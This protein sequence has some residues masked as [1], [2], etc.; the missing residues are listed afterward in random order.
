[1]FPHKPVLLNTV[2]LQKPVTADDLKIRTD[3]TGKVSV[4]VMDTLQWIPL[5]EG[6]TVALP[7]RDGV[8]EADL[9]QD[10]LYIAQVERHG[11]NGNIGK[12]F[13][14]GFKLKEGA[15]ASSVGH[16]NHNIIVLG[17]NH[18]DMAVAVNRV[19]DLQ[20]GQVIVR[21]GAVADELAF[22][23]LGLLSDLSAE[24][25]A[26]KKRAMNDLIREMGSEIP[27]PFMFLSFIS[28]AAI[29]AY[30]VTD[31]GFI[32]VLNQKVIDPIIGPAA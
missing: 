13:M 22:P 3:I 2:H 17:A 15:I 23:I 19:A 12:A 18:A 25:I 32:D 31:H 27:L 24:E 28:L 29:P 9:A 14:G 6:R 30:A 4:Q 20:G 26:E 10:A 1:V 7:V 5:T 8:V 11:K 16:D 21:N